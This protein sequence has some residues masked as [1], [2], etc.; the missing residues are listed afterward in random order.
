MTWHGGVLRSRYESPKLQVSP[1]CDMNSRE[2]AVAEAFYDDN[3][4]TIDGHTD[5]SFTED[6]GKRFEGYG[7]Q[8][9]LQHAQH[10]VL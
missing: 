9:R 2:F 1:K 3:G 4:I 8:V 10:M 7:W 6:V 5:L